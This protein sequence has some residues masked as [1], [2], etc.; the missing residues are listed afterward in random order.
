MYCQ[1]IIVSYNTIDSQ[2]KSH[3]NLNYLNTMIII[4]HGYLAKYIFYNF[5]QDIKYNKNVI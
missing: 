3:V 2:G 4:Y 5:L 1:S